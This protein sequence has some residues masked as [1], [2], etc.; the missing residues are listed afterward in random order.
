MIETRLKDFGAL[1]IKGCKWC[2][3]STTGKHFAKSVVELQN[4]EENKNIL[5]VAADQP[6][7]ILSGEKPRL[8]DE[9][10]DAP[11]IWDA[12]R[13]DVDNSNLKGQ[14]ILTGSSTPRNNK[15]KHSGAGRFATIHMRPMSLYESGD[16]NGAVSLISLFD[17][18][19]N[20]SG[21]S[22]INLE[23]IAYLCARGGWP[24]NIVNKPSDPI[25]LAKEYLEVII[26]RGEGYDQIPYYSSSR[27][28]ALLRSLSRNIASPIKLTTLITDIQNNTDVNISDVT[29]ANYMSI[30]EQSFLID[31][32]EAWSP[33]L[34]SKTQMRNSRKRCFADPSIA[35]SSLYANQHDLILDYETFGLIFES[36][37]IR[38]LKVYAEA[39]GGDLYYYRDQNGTECDAVI[40]FVDGRWGGIE[41]KLS[42]NP[43]KIEEAATSLKHFASIVDTETMQEPSFLMVLSGIC[44]YAYRRDDGVYVVPIGCLKP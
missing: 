31:D 18:K 2:G 19:K 42:D 15:P 20:I 7:I 25:A 13:Y 35:V 36:M 30:L 10:Q 27:M 28:K 44:R 40:H 38:D 34:R 17:G 29:I 37:A 1:W 6:S 33:K 14:Y 12:I 16:S 32:V 21:T 24:S 8:I 26:D 11:E 41:I 22:D 43:E 3:K 23:E 5:A 39:I 4:T 9:W